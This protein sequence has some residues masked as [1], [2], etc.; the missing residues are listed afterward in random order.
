MIYYC[1]K[2]ITP[3]KVSIS[4]LLFDEEQKNNNDKNTLKSYKFTAKSEKANKSVKSSK[5]KK[6]K[7]VLN[8][9]PKKIRV[10]KVNNDNSFDKKKQNKDIILP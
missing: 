9:P 7:N 3:I 2:D 6:N 8:Y 5:K 1:C 4:K 10:K